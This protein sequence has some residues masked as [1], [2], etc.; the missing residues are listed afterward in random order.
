MSFST[1][2]KKRGV[3]PLLPLLSLYIRISNKSLDL[4]RKILALIHSLPTQKI[5]R[6]KVFTPPASFKKIKLIKIQKNME[7]KL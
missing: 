4:V 2:H 3:L 7:K 6:F 1:K 5:S